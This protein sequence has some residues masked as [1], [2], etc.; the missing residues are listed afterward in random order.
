MAAPSCGFGVQTNPNDTS[1]RPTKQTCSL[2]T[3]VNATRALKKCCSNYNSGEG[4]LVY[5]EGCY[6][7]CTSDSTNDTFLDCLSDNYDNIEGYLCTINDGRE[8]PRNGVGA[9]ASPSLTGI[10]T[11]L[12]LGSAML[13]I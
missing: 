6:I 1:H 5:S 4:L 2:P 11:V 8:K 3:S 12:L 9:Q 7:S 13:I 10:L